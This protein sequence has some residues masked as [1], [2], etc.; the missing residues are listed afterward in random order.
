MEFFINAERPAYA[1][2]AANIGA[3]D[4]DA[5]N[6]N[7]GWK[8]GAFGYDI[9]APMHSVNQVNIRAAR[10]AKQNFRSRCSSARRV[11]C[12]ILHADVC[13][14]FCDNGTQCPVRKFTAFDSADDDGAQKTPRY[15][16]SR[17]REKASRQAARVDFC[18][19]GLLIV[20]TKKEYFYIW[21]LS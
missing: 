6:E 7:S 10:V 21:N 18:R 12:P 5:P 15:A 9:K 8:L 16:E 19:Y 1:P 17:F 2:G 14:G 11:A 20:H 4:F 3:A 13:F